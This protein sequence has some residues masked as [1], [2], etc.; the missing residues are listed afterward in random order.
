MP[1]LAKLQAAMLQINKRRDVWF[2][3]GRRRIRHRERGELH[4]RLPRGERREAMAIVGQYLAPFVQ[5]ANLQ[6]LAFPRNAGID[7]ETIARE[8]GL[9]IDR[10]K[11]AIGDLKSCGYL[12]GFQPREEKPEGLRG[13]AAIR[14]LTGH[15][16]KAL[17]LWKAFQR[18]REI[19]GLKPL[20][21]DAPITRM[22]PQLAPRAAAVTS[23]LN[24]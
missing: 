13:R 2:F 14:W 21:G 16:L 23:R 4:D 22:V 5:V 7:R 20:R 17:G 24:L 18:L 9:S 12:G 15:F 19:L 6:V 3:A 1:F 11:G 8:T 10:V